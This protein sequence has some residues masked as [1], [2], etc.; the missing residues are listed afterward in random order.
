M[1]GIIYRLRKTRQLYMFMYTRR[2]EN[3]WNERATEHRSKACHLVHRNG[4]KDPSPAAYPTSRFQT[5]LFLPAFEMIRARSVL[6]VL[7][8]S[9]ATAKRAVRDERD[10]QQS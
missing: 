7:S 6:I 5:D 8:P 9:S 3:D 10:S 4:C 2:I 1:T